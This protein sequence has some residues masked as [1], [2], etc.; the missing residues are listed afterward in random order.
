MPGVYA[1]FSLTNQ[2]SVF[3]WQAK[4]SLCM[5]IIRGEIISNYRNRQSYDEDPEN[6]AYSTNGST[7]DCLGHHVTIANGCHGHNR[8]PKGFWDTIKIRLS[9]L[10]GFDLE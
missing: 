7:R 8:P 10:F 5:R 1:Q 6:G 3:L 2:A 4:P 9:S